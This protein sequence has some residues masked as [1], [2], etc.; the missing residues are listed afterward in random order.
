MHTGAPAWRRYDPLKKGPD[1]GGVDHGLREVHLT[2]VLL[3]GEA[4]RRGDALGSHDHC[5]AALSSPTVTGC[6]QGLSRGFRGHGIVTG[7]PLLE[8]SFP[9]MPRLPKHGAFEEAVYKPVKIA[10]SGCRRFFASS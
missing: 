6:L 1:G 10:M 3:P 9:S 5:G 2:D 7:E 8:Y 4:L